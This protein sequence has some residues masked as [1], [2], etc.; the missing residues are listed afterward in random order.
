M[1]FPGSRWAA[2]GDDLVPLVR[3]RR[4]PFVDASGRLRRVRLPAPAINTCDFKEV[5]QLLVRQLLKEISQEGSPGLADGWVPQS[6]TARL[7]Q[8]PDARNRVSPF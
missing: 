8:M 7:T 4:H 3:E 1:E 6:A 2:N 5:A